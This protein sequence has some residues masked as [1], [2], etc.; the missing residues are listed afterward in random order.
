MTRHL[1]RLVAP[2]DFVLPCGALHNDDL[3]V[4]P[5]RTENVVGDEVLA[6][7][8][9]IAVLAYTGVAARVCVARAGGRSAGAAAGRQSTIRRSPGD[10]GWRFDAIRSDRRLGR[11]PVPVAGPHVGISDDSFIESPDN[12]R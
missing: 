10:S 2:L 4:G 3:A 11:R 7:Q 6:G 8:F 12:L 9:R 5:D 1:R